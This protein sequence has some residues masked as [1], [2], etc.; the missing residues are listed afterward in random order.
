MTLNAEI[1]INLMAYAITIGV[2]YGGITQRI[3]QLEKKV[4]KHNNLIERMYQVES[5]IEIIEN[6]LEDK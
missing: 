4:D 3:K 2:V 5:Q 1:I 6:K